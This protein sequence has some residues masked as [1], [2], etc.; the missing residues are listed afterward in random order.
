MMI[1]DRKSNFMF[2]EFQLLY[3]TS[4]DVC[5]QNYDNLSYT[6]NVDFTKILITPYRK[7]VIPPPMSEKEV[8]I[9]DI[10]KTLWFYRNGIFVLFKTSIGYINWVNGKFTTEEFQY[11]GVA[12]SII[13]IESENKT[14]NVSGVI[15]ITWSE[16]NKK[17][18][19][20]IEVLV[21]VNSDDKL[22]IYKHIS[23]S[24]NKVYSWCVS[25]YKWYED[26]YVNLEWKE[27]NKTYTN[28][29]STNNDHED[30]NPTMA[31]FL[32]QQEDEED[33]F[34]QYEKCVFI[35]YLNKKIQK[36]IPALLKGDERG[37]F[38]DIWFEISHLC[39]QIDAAFLWG[40]LCLFTLSNNSKLSING[41]LFSKECTSLFISREFLFFI[42]STQAL[43]HHL[44]VYNLNRNLPL[45]VPDSKD[46][47]PSHIVPKLPGTE[48]DSFHIR[49]VER[50]AKI[51]CWNM[52]KSIIQMP[53]GNLEGKNILKNI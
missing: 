33:T 15:L 10:P 45:P 36:Y 40:E 42:N 28:R 2:Y 1:I 27:L 5:Y 29:K 49:N 32:R 22:I 44:F 24:T 17:K 39:A 35:Q 48:D 13:F 16:H 7:V 19:S 9:N 11:K 51:V 6:A 25:P 38:K 46:S 50:G 23:Q 12:K 4:S 47:D 34:D 21:S 14:E 18:D 20:L 52:T 41:I 30:E 8:E 43:F 26:D 31:M 37:D 53:R 3:Q